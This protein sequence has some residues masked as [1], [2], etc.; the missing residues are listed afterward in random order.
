MLANGNVT[1]QKGTV[2]G[3]NAVYA[4][5]YKYAFAMGSSIERTCN[6]SGS[7]STE[8]I[9]CGGFGKRMLILK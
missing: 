8:R 7:W 2:V 1:T 3:A 9:E 5:N 4:C 6:S